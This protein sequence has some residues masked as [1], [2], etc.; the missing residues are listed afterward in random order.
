MAKLLAPE[1]FNQ[2]TELSIKNDSLSQDVTRMSQE[3]DSLQNE[4][5]HLNNKANKLINEFDSLLNIQK[6]TSEKNE[7]LVS[8]KEELHNTIVEKDKT[9]ESFEQK[10]DYFLDI[11]W[12]NLD[13]KSQSILAL[14]ARNNNRRLTERDIAHLANL[15]YAKVIRGTEKMAAQKILRICLHTKK[16]ET[17][18]SI[19]DKHLL[20]FVSNKVKHFD[21][22]RLAEI[23]ALIEEF[24]LEI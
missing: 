15:P 14:F 13:A 17:C 7:L 16:D 10:M 23:D 4:F 2:V 21:K 11:F 20:E 5:F 3:K 8:E 1:I 19:E 18:F 24:G 12:N 6:A 9:I 22:K